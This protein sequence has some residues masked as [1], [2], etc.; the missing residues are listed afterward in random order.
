MIEF[1][2]IASKI[3]KIAGSP[4]GFVVATF[5][6]ILWALLGPLFNYSE[7]W[8]LFIN[9]TTTIVTFLMVFLIQNSQNRD[10]KAM[11]LKLDEL[12]RS[13]KGARELFMDAEEMPDDELEKLHQ[14]S[15]N[16]HIKYSKEQKTRLG[17]TTTITDTFSDTM[18]SAD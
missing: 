1:N 2:K 14:D 15:K 18:I 5:I 16:I 7:K 8:Q 17:D 13:S 11:H 12:I 9:T 3:S 6:V 10:T 4:H